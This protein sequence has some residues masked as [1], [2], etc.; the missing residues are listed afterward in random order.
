M[1]RGKRYDVDDGPKLNLKKVFA[2]IMAIVVIIL[3]IIGIQKLLTKKNNT[4]GVITSSSYYT[5]FKDDKWGVINSNGDTVI[6]PSYQELIVIPN[7]KKDVFLCTYAVNYE[8]GTYKTKALNSKN[9]EIL[10]GYEQIEPVANYDGDSVWYEENMLKIEKDMAY[11]LIDLD[12]NEIIPAQYEEISV[13]QSVDHALKV[14]KDGKYGLVNYS[15]QTILEPQYDDIDDVHGSNLYVVTVE[16]TKKIIDKDGQDIITKGFDNVV[17]ISEMETENAGIVFEK[18]KKYGFMSLTGE[19]IIE[20]T[21]DN[22]VETSTGKLIAKQDNKYGI[23][24]TAKTEIYPFGEE[25]I[26]Y[27]KKAD[28]YI[29]E[30][31]GLNAKILNKDLEEKLSGI[32]LDIDTEKNYIKMRVQDE[33][34][35]YNFQFE[36][37]QASEILTSNTLFLSKKDGKYGFVDKDG[38]VVVDYQYDDATE[39]NVDGYVSVKKDGKWGSID[40]QGKVVVEPTYNLDEYLQ[41]DFIGRWHKGLDLNMNYYSQE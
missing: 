10:Q 30:D 26:T 3:L 37:K 22:L 29:I 16:G 33:Y 15:N 41:V 9:Q 13:M 7:S 4:S 2:V 12:G 14:K 19:I 6:D 1:S 18:E 24:D 32:L 11:G 20:P 27:N 8:D 36:E 35:Y 23:I 34:K 28:I 17:S 21:Y 39:Q 40:R 5:S 31:E 38:K 25:T